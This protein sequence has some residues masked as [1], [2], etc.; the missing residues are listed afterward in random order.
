M[1]T[2]P[3]SYPIVQL[4]TAFQA[5]GIKF[6]VAGMSAANLQGVLASIR[7]ALKLEKSA[8]RAGRKQRRR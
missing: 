6:M 8:K 1:A 3:K 4:F 2:G 5:E 7:Q